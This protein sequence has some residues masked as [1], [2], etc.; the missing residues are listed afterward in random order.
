MTR[1]Q[2]I[3]WIVW[4]SLLACALAVLF[5]GWQPIGPRSAHYAFQFLAISA[6]VRL[7]HYMNSKP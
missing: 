3:A 2:T 1:I 7:F 6:A 5:V 4:A